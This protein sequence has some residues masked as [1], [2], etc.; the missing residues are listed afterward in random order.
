MAYIPVYLHYVVGFS[1]VHMIYFGQHVQSHKKGAGFFRQQQHVCAHKTDSR[2]RL[3]IVGSYDKKST[4]GTVGI[5][6]QKQHKVD[7]EIKMSWIL[8][9]RTNT[10]QNQNP[11]RMPNKVMVH[12]KPTKE[13]SGFHESKISLI[14]FGRYRVRTHQ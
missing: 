5:T 13:A 4:V 2:V 12:S 6:E 7:R 14:P 8:P 11:P 3:R 1:T 9:T 10:C